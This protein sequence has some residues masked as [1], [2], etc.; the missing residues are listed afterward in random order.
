MPDFENLNSSEEDDPLGG[1]DPMA[2]LESLAVRQGATEGFT[3]DH[4]VDVPDIDPN[5]VVIDEPGY[6]PSESLS[7][8][9]EED[10]PPSYEPAASAYES[11]PPESAYAPPPLASDQELPEGVDPLAWL[12]ALAA[13]QGATEGFTTDHNVEVPDI[14]PNS[15]VI[16]EPGYTPSESF[17][18]RREEVPQEAA[19]PV[20]PEY[21]PPAYDESAYQQQEYDYAAY[22]QPA[23]EPAYDQGAGLPEGVDPLAWLEALAARQGA[24]EGFTTDH[25]VEVPDIDPNSVV[26]DEPGYTPSESFSRRREEVPQEAAP[27]VEPEYQPPA[28][29][30]SAYQQQEYDYAAY[31]QPA[32]SDE[33]SMPEGVDPL[34]WLE[35]LAARQGAT[36]GFTTDHNVEVPD[37]DPNSVVIDEPG[38]TPSESFSRRREEVPQEAAPPPAEEVPDWLTEAEEEPASDVSWLDALADDTGAD[39]ADF[40]SDL[41]AEEA[42]LPGFDLDITEPPALTEEAIPATH[43]PEELLASIDGLSDE[44]IAQMQVAGTLTPAQELAWLQRQAMDMAKLR[45][46][47]S[48][49]EDYL[50]DMELEP[51]EASELPPW[52][53]SAVVVDETPDSAIAFIDE[54]TT[55]PAPDEVPEWLHEDTSAIEMPELDLQE[56]APPTEQREAVVIPDFLNLEE[57][58]P[59]VDE[60]AQALDEEHQ[61]EE[62][63]IV[64]ETPDWFIEAKQKVHAEE[65]L[66]TAF[67]AVELEPE[68]TF[69]AETETAEEIPDWISGLAEAPSEAV[70]SGMDDLPEWLRP[71]AEGVAGEDDLGIDD[72]LRDIQTSRS[73]DTSI[74]SPF[75]EVVPESVQPSVASL[76]PAE[77]ERLAQARP[78]GL[79][80]WAQPATPTVAPPP[81]T[82]PAVPSSV[83]QARPAPPVERQRVAVSEQPVP[84]PSPPPTVPELAEFAAYRAA[85]ERNPHDHSARLGLARALNQTGDVQ[86]SLNQY[87]TLVENMVEFD[88]VTSD[89]VVI[90]EQHPVARRLLGDVYMRQGYLQEALDA[91]RGALNNL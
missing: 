17:S 56:L 69:E 84:P 82:P 81:A 16:D 62:Q 8:R 90:A 1:I 59:S 72:W 78:G 4:N 44:Q 26:I 80:Q 30:E 5:S 68:S 45:E 64:A 57:Y 75:A 11:A 21:Q 3:T 76:P 65:S 33:Y 29:D 52:L 39:V 37:I 20:E 58:D 36:E 9:R 31:Q 12:E 27:P 47:A 38:Y 23:V 60:W 77:T 28:Y 35:A 22:Q 40:L 48:A 18:R 14:D 51:A 86:S 46:T 25:N 53:Q 87:Q 63:G 71:M 15:V 85:L 54:I 89:L 32:A 83:Q 55:P 70:D 42:S 34:A 74:I 79:P 6:T 66:E 50:S 7:R 91:Y 10:Q 88:N 43:T 13:R 61:L 49:E 2:W 24:T 41:V 67:E 73:T 19:P